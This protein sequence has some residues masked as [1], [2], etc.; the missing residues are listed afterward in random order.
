MRGVFRPCV[1]GYFGVWWGQMIFAIQFLT[2]LTMLGCGAAAV[3]GGMR[4]QEAAR[5][6]FALGWVAALLLFAANAGLVQAPP[7]GNMRQVLSFF[8]LVMAPAAYYLRRCRG[9]ELT[10]WLAGAAAVAAMG[11]CCMPLQAHWR[12][13]PALQSPWFAPHVTAYVLAYGL[14]A[15]SAVLAAVSCFRRTAEGET[16]DMQAADALV[17]LAFPFLCFGLGS[18]A[19][20][21]DAA[22]GTY[23]GWD[24]KEAWSLLTWG[25]YLLYFHAARPLPAYRRPLLL[26]GFAAVI[27][28]FLVVNL[29]PQIQSLHSYAS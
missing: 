23:W 5:F 10:G 27:I 28:T 19:L 8:P 7:F 9:L 3:A 20:W 11:A 14:L 26:L 12:Q 17:R 18:G 29:L 25:L 13:M 6:F 22:W 1:G 2:V 15:V 24:I 4:R 21:A 16:A